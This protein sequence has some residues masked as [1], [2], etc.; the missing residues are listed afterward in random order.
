MEGKMEQMTSSPCYA[1]NLFFI[2]LFFEAH[3]FPVY[4]FVAMY[5]HPHSLHVSSGPTSLLLLEPLGTYNLPLS[6]AS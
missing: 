6:E 5:L 3:S 1:L 4:L 2:F